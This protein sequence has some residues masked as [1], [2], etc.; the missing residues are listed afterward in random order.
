MLLWLQLLL[1]LA[2]IG[3]AGYYL[4]RYGDISAEKT[5][6]YA[7]WIGA[8]TSLPELVTGISP[9]TAA[10]TEQRTR[11]HPT[12]LER[13]LFYIFNAWLLFRHG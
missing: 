7:S 12:S 11:P 6:M 10:H 1:C 13:L 8:A 3:Y 4:S 2:T 9:V 5:G